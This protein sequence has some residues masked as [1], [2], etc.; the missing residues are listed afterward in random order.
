MGRGSGAGAARLPMV[1][2]A[3]SGSST[4]GLVELE[5]CELFSAAL[6]AFAA[7]AADAA[8][9][10]GPLKTPALGP[11]DRAVEVLIDDLQ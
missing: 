8:L 10:Q 5:R 6:N 4:G 9:D 3:S 7:A 2:A 1:W 11:R